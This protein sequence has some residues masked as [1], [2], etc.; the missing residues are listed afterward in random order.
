MS[1]LL[2]KAL[3]LPRYNPFFREGCEE[4]EYKKKATQCVTHENGSECFT[5]KFWSSFSSKKNF[6]PL[7]NKGNQSNAIACHIDGT[8]RSTKGLV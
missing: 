5:P 6:N 3:Q 4:E 7:E 8:R 1:F 2:L